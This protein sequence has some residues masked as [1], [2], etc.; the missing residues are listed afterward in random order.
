MQPQGPVPGRGLLA[1]NGLPCPQCRA[2]WWGCLACVFA[3]AAARNGP[4]QRSAPHGAGHAVGPMAYPV[5]RLGPWVLPALCC[6]AVAPPWA[7]CWG[8]HAAPHGAHTGA[9]AAHQCNGPLV[10]LRMPLRAHTKAGGPRRGCNACCA[11]GG[12][13]L[14]WPVCPPAPMQ[15][16]ARLGPQG[17]APKPA[18]WDSRGCMGAG[19]LHTGHGW[20]RC[21][22]CQPP[23]TRIARGPTCPAVLLLPP[24]RHTGLRKGQP[25]CCANPPFVPATAPLWGYL[26]AARA[27][28]LLGLP[29]WAVGLRP[30]AVAT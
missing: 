6:C 15:R 21:C 1:C 17:P 24:C 5:R 27:G 22:C 4:M 26:L 2:P 10:P 25:Q 3:S 14:A 13:R 19:L 16:R 23:P 12:A 18:P 30:P 9:G 28:R 7:H 29:C 20:P 11:S 8:A